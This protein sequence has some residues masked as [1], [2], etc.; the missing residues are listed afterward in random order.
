METRRSWTKAIGI[1]ILG[2]VVGVVSVIGLDRDSR[3]KAVEY[4]Q[5]GQ[6]PVSTAPQPLAPAVQPAAFFGALPTFSDLAKRVSSS[7]VNISTTKNARRRMPQGFHRMP[8]DPFFDDFFEH[9]FDGPGMDAPQK[10]LGSGFIINSEGYIIT[11][12]HVVEGADEIQVM[13]DGKRKYDGKIVGSDSKTDLAVIK[14]TAANLPAA[15]LGDSSQVQV[16]DWV[17]A[18]GNPFGLDHTVTAGIVSAK[19][20]VI[21]AGP[22]D[23][24]IQTD[25]SINP[26]NSGGPLF[27]LKGEVVGVNTAIVAAGQ[28]IGFAIPINMAKELV[29][30]LIS[31]GR[32][33]RAWLGVGIQDITPEL[34]KSFNLP[35]QKGALVSNVF[36]NS[37]AE[38]AGLKSG[39]VIRS[40]EGKPIEESHDLPTMVAREPVGKTSAMSVLREGRELSLQV[41]LG[42]MDKGDQ[43]AEGGA[44][45]SSAELGLTCRD[46]TPEEAAQMGLA[47]DNRGVSIVNVESGSQA[48]IAGVQIGDVLLSINGQKINGVADYIAASKK[49]K[50]GEIV[51]LFIKREDS[52]VFLAFAK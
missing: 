31:K 51:R 17:M 1:G 18:V 43:V 12:N 15:T 50:T 3:V 7:V 2:A 23:D 6:K 36:P 30:Q 28:G 33:T 40:F 34:A 49:V 10:S 35:D 5:E 25:A 44:K 19:G 11:N 39:D 45:S 14:I 32:V 16:G 48:E 41:T 52:T 4:F 37:P 22:Y 38:K 24:F 21:G 27:N 20:R 9:F 13:V 26:G 46:V 47:Q 42:E 8:R 29:P